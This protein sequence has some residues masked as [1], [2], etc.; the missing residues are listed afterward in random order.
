MTPE[1]W[2]NKAPKRTFL[3]E[4]GHW[5]P[6]AIQEMHLGLIKKTSFLVHFNRVWIMSQL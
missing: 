1:N 4:A 5:F 3:L 6:S 2:T